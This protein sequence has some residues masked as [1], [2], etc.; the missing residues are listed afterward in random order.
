M[1]HVREIAPPAPRC[2]RPRAAR[3]PAA[4]GTHGRGTGRGRARRFA[5]ILRDELNVRSVRLLDAEDASGGVRHQQKLTVNARAAGPRLGKD[6]QQVIQGAKAGDWSVSD[7]GVVTAGGIALEPGEYEL[8][9]VVVEAAKPKAA[10][11][12]PP[13]RRLRAARHRGHPRA[14][15]RGPGAR[16]G[17]RRAAGPQGRRTRRQRPHRASVSAM[18]DVVAALLATAELVTTETLTVELEALAADVQVPQVRAATQG[19]A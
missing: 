13:R 2:A 12:R 7:G 3:A 9:T 6:V 16:R 15:G 11:A 18:Q 5:D 17:P 14:R 8:E 19:G 1:D 10:H 4:A